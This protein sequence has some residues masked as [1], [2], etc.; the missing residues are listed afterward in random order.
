MSDEITEFSWKLQAVKNL[1]P[2]C[3]FSTNDEGE[4]NWGVAILWVNLVR[5]K[6]TQ[7]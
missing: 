3:S 5:Q 6:L 7:K 2:N 4:I 1:A